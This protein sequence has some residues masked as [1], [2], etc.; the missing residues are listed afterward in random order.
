MLNYPQ[1]YQMNANHRPLPVPL[2]LRI[3]SDSLP[4]VK[5][6]F[7]L[8]RP[9]SLVTYQPSIY[10]IV[11]TALNRTLP[12]NIASVFQVREMIRHTK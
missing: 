5:H 7:H 12:F 4:V 6:N 8:A 10:S 1:A 9:L 3:S 2:L 11:I